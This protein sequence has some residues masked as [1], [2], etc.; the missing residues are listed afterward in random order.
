MKRDLAQLTE[1]EFDLAIIGG[2]IYGA[3]A[4]WEAALQGLR[5]ALIEREDFGSKTSS[6]SLKIIHG[7]LRYIQ[8]LD[9]KRMRESIRERR[10]LMKL[11]P[12]LV[13]PL[14]CI[15]PTYGHLGKGPEVMRVALLLNDLVGWDRNRIDDPQ[16][17]LPNGKVLSREECERLL[18]GVRREN[19][20]GGALWY[21]CQ[22]YN[23]ERLLLAYL[24]SASAMGAVLANYVSAEGLIFRGN[25]VVGV[26]ARDRLANVPLQIRAR[27]AINAAGPWVNRVFQ[28]LRPHQQRPP[29]Q[30][31]WAMNLVTKKI[32]SGFAVGATGRH[33]VW[34]DGRLVDKSRK[35]FFIAPWRD[36]SLVGTIHEP[37]YGDPSDFR[38]RER[39]IARFIEE[40]NGAYPG[41]ELKREDV[42]FFYGGLLPMDRPDPK[43]GEVVLTKHY[44]LIDHSQA[45]SVD[46]MISVVG[47]KYTTARDVGRKTVRLA[48]RKLDRPFH[49]IDVESQRLFGGEIPRFQEFWQQI[50]DDLRNQLPDAAIDQLAYNYGSEYGRI[51]ALG[52][53]NPEWL[54]P[55]PGT[56]VLPAEVVH[57]VREEM[58]QRL[59]D[60]VWRRT[61]LGSAGLPSD[62]VLN[63][64]A[65]LM[66]REL[67][68]SPEKVAEEIEHTKAHYRPAE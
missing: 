26:Q 17:I 22:V 2:G 49:E 45:D 66:A 11:A 46:G 23:S 63:Q 18:P 67:D 7:G 3:A 24:H 8:H 15:M 4:T 38:I 52:K 6:N 56:G 58:A 34:Q 57:A 10:V 41:A 60:V 25:R 1:Q 31:S 50:H 68:W 55:F 62:D 53:E 27:L 14:P 64:V 29:V 32:V 51:L 61:E 33:K 16:K 35:V 21:D 9:Y 48:A 5:V 12:H 37:Y 42:K 47:V 40:I 44:K 36:Y 28:W 30:W 59:I 65:E 39:E 13:H 43:S 20:T 54:R 19:L